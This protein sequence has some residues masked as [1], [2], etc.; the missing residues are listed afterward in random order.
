MQKLENKCRQKIDADEKQRAAEVLFYLIYHLEVPL[1]CRINLRILNSLKIPLKRDIKTPLE[2][3][4][5]VIS[6]NENGQKV[7]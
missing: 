7:E 1:I 5:K 2:R 3:T 6:F 4:Y